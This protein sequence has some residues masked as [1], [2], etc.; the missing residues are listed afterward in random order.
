MKT[1]QNLTR[2]MGGFEVIQRTKDGM[3]NATHLLIQWNKS[4]G[5]KKELKH[6]LHQN[7]NTKEFIKVLENEENLKGRNSAYLS[8]R[9]KY[10]GT[11][12]HPYLFVKFAMWINPRF[13]YHVIKFVYDE[14]IKYRNE[15]GDAYREMSSAIQKIVPKRDMA[16]RMQEVAKALNYIVYGTHQSG[17]RNSKAEEKKARELCELEKDVAKLINKG[18]IKNY[19]ALLNYLRDEW[20]E[21]HTPKMLISPS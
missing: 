4:Y 14:L 12:M 1:N 2:Q 13:E 6:F 3:F 18:F 16:H 11:W 15:A 9:G 10:G 20:K 17:I 19:N 7:A 8:A 5:M 21:R